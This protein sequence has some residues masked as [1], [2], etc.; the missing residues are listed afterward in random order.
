MYQTTT[1]LPVEA[2]KV[3]DK[4][5]THF[6]ELKRAKRDIITK[7]SQCMY[8]ANRILIEE[9]INLNQQVGI[10]RRVGR[11]REFNESIIA[12]DSAMKEDLFKTLTGWQ[13]LR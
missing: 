11:L 13:D 9:P 2:T 6:E 7:A 5:E 8:E 12:K 3:I 10:L 4:F 1:R